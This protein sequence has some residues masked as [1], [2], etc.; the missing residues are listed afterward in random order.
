MNGLKVSELSFS[1]GTK[2]A[3]ENVSLEVP[4]GR[5]CALLGPNGAGKSTLFA[6]LTRLLSSPGG[7]IQIAGHDLTKTPG[8]A[9]S[10]LG[11]VFQQPTLDL[12]L[13]VRQNL[14][15]FAA[16]HGIAGRD[17]TRR[18]DAALDKLAML[19]RAT[20]KA[21]NLNGGHRR[22]AEIA[23]A[24]I[25]DPAVLLLDEPTVGLDAAARAS[26][27]GH[28]HQLS[29]EGTTV[30]WATHLTDEVGRDDQLVILHQ[31]RV[32]AQGRCEEVCGDAPLADR[33]LT[34][35]AQPR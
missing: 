34:L 3:L 4:A 11:I 23:R 20:E 5:F 24:L 35:T 8:A 19:E 22:R 26:I 18:I 32:L 25:H 9:L 2:P 6:L 16:L 33:F 31:A 27:T 15:Y 14:S 21:R 12:D 1:Y 29:K 13:S 10:K 28:V 30:L 17:A 7:R